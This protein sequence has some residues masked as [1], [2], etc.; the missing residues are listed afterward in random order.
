MY[1]HEYAHPKDERLM[2]LV[3]AT[4]CVML[5]EIVVECPGNGLNTPGAPPNERSLPH[6]SPWPPLP[7]SPMKVTVELHEPISLT[8][9]GRYLN[10]FCKATSVSPT[11]VMSLKSDTPLGKHY[12]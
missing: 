10:T 3:A 11:V 9:A 8:F 12:T 7:P 5:P 2:M 1:M 6:L 4:L